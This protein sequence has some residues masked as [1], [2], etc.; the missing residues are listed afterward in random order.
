MKY[1]LI[2]DDTDQK[3][4][5]TELEKKSKERSFPI[6]CFYFN[7]NKKECQRIETKQDGSKE[8]LIE[9]ELVLEELRKEFLSTHID[10]I[11]IDYRISDDY[12]TGLDIVHF[13]KGSSWKR[14]THYVIYSS[15]SDEI[16]EKLQK[17]LMSLIED[18]NRLN[19]FVESFYDL[20]PSKIFN[21]KTDQDSYID[22][23]Y[24]F[25][26]K[27]K[28]PLNNKLSQKL[29]NHPE[30]I[31]RNIF[32]RFEGKPLKYL[33]EL[34]M[35]NTEESDVFEDEFLDR[36]VDHFIDLKY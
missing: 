18:K 2:I 1:C 13:L 36:C 17:E 8:I 23:L 9:K 25:I 34:V 21:R 3:D 14:K 19:D 31:F 24:E 28:T 32:P 11:A 7:P 22:H 6:K 16:K 27:N 5:I 15:D 29:S 4:E 33:S 12:I 30:E 35:I 10:L 20:N 26:K